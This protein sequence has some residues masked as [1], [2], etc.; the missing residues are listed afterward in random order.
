MLKEVE[1]AVL[2]AYFQSEGTITPLKNLYNS[3]I[4]RIM[5]LAIVEEFCKPGE[6]TRFPSMATGFDRPVFGEKVIYVRPYSSFEPNMNLYKNTKVKPLPK[7]AS[8]D[9]VG[10]AIKI[11]KDM[12]MKI[13]IIDAP[14]A[15]P[16]P[17]IGQ[18]KWG[19]PYPQ[20]GLDE[21]KHVRVDG[22]RI[23]GIEAKGCF[24]N[25]DVRNYALARIKD[26][27]SHYPDID[28]L[29]LDHIEFPTY[30]IKDNFSCFCEHCY[31]EA[32]KMGYELD[33]IKEEVYNFYK[34]V[35]NISKQTIRNIKYYRSLF[36]SIDLLINNPLLFNWIKFKTDSVV[37]FV[38]EV[39]SILKEE[40]KNVA[41]G[42]TGFTP[43]LGYLGSRNYKKLAEY[44]DVLLPKF[45]NEHWG[46]IAKWWAEELMEYNANLIDE[47]CIEFFYVL[48]GWS[49]LGAPKKIDEID[50]SSPKGI[51]PPETLITES[52]KI[53][54]MVQEKSK[55]FC[56]LHCWG[57]KEN[58]E[59]KLRILKECPIDGI[60]LWNY[61][62]LSDE[63]LNILK[64]YLK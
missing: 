53:R 2:T 54:N 56:F 60:A 25:P 11:A 44:C 23:D 46:L 64:E 45:Y 16:T 34:R 14:T 4:K 5:L 3:N 59:K 36:D 49:E 43:T 27:V 61:G 7:K 48:T 37:E 1:V 20:P 18:E 41:L 62:L 57:T 40:N 19:Y 33:K 51:I 31:K 8:K 42:L 63:K 32:K 39:R 17:S 10:E 50:P 22:K 38:K 29:I 28:T 58:L 35:K 26:I 21:Y 47:E 12:G 52:V 6:G 15:V 55:I 24:N 30:N 13:D 9:Y